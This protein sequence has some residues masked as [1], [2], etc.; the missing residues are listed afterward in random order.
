MLCFK[1]GY[2]C[3]TLNKATLEMRLERA[4]PIKV[5]AQVGILLINPDSLVG[6]EL[7]N[8]CLSQGPNPDLW[9]PRLCRRQEIEMFGSRTKVGMSA[10][11]RLNN[12]KI[13]ANRNFKFLNL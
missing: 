13:I 3:G 1:M 8:L 9:P 6:G 12:L 2:G 10:T 5:D 11:N 4:S 7:E